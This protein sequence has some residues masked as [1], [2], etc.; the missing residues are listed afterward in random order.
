MPAGNR[1]GWREPTIILGII[2]VVVAAAAFGRDLVDFTFPDPPPPAATDAVPRAPVETVDP[3]ATSTPEGYDPNMPTD[4]PFSSGVVTAGTDG[5]DLDVVPAAP[6]AASGGEAEFRTTAAD[7]FSTKATVYQWDEAGSPTE[8]QCT[9]GIGAEGQAG[10][11][12]G[13]GDLAGGGWAF[14]LR[15]SEGRYAYVAIG[16]GADAT[17]RVSY[18]VW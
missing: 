12:V 13:F 2:S 6:P 1:I 9:G 17:V 10:I 15:T 3:D 7:A 14:C 5:I 18:F 8:G 11:A 4:E 16:D